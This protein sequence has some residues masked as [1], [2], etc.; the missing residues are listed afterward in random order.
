MLGGGGENWGCVITQASV[1]HS[2]IQLLPL[3]SNH[4]L[5]SVLQKHR[6]PTETLL[7]HSQR[8]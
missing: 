5:V 3:H 7:M 1:S 2:A 4:L 6:E 8:K